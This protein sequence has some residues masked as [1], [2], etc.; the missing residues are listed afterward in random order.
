MKDSSEANHFYFSSR[1]VQKT[2]QYWRNKQSPGNSLQIGIIHF[3][4]CIAQFKD[5]RS[6]RNYQKFQLFVKAAGWGITV[7]DQGG[8]RP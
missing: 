2:Q 8:G 4:N 5:I 6:L 1:F 7:D 3:M